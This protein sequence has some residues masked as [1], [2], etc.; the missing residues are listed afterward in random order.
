M[1]HRRTSLSFWPV[2]PIQLKG[3]PSMTHM[4]SVLSA[5]ILA[6]LLGGCGDQTPTG[7]D[8]SGHNHAAAEHADHQGDDGHDDHANQPTDSADTHHKGDGHE[9]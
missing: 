9:H 4:T 5:T 1:S 6:T 2:S 3:I 7:T 8:H